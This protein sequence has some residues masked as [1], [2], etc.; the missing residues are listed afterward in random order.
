MVLVGLYEWRRIW[1]VSLRDADASRCGHRKENRSPAPTTKRAAWR[2]A[3]RTPPSTSAKR[4]RRIH[5]RSSSCSGPGAAGNLSL[6]NPGLSRR[7]SVDRGASRS[8]RLGARPASNRSGPLI[9]SLQARGAQTRSSRGQGNAEASAEHLETALNLHGGKAVAEMPL[10]FLLPPFRVGVQWSYLHRAEFHRCVHNAFMASLE[11]V[12]WVRLPCAT[13]NPSSAAHSAAIWIRPMLP[14]S[15]M[16]LRISRIDTL[17]PTA[18]CAESDVLLPGFVCPIVLATGDPFAKAGNEAV[19]PLRGSD[20]APR[21]RRGSQR[22]ARRRRP[23][24]QRLGACHREIPLIEISRW[25]AMKGRDR[26]ARFTRLLDPEAPAGALVLAHVST[27]SRWHGRSRG[28]DAHCPPRIQRR[29][30]GSLSGAA[31]VW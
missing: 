14:T 13:R 7:N 15:K 10:R 2:R 21:Q 16:S 28:E 11:L 18:G 8:M 23:K 4:R 12:S 3:T 25:D 24:I 5:V 29:I 26:R 22:N 27:S 30:A 1:R 9:D 17:G 6:F 20:R 19:E 31:S